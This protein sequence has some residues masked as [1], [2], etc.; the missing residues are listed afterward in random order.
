MPAHDLQSQLEELRSQL[1]QDTPL[2]EEER[3]S[4]QAIALDIEARLADDGEAE[5]TDSLVDG[6]NLAVERFE[7]SHPSMA[8]TLRNILQSLANMGI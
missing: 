3:A 4:L 1:A 7:V 2:T 6:V 5:Y 8:I